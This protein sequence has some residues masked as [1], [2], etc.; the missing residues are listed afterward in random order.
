MGERLPQVEQFVPE[1]VDAYDEHVVDLPSPPAVEVTGITCHSTSSTTSTTVESSDPCADITCPEGEVCI[2]GSCAPTTH[3]LIDLDVDQA[4]HFG[5]LQ[6]DILHDCAEGTFDGEDDQV[7]C[8]GNPD[9]NAYSAFHDTDCEVASGAPRVSL[10]AITLNSFMGPVRVATC[11]YSDSTG[12]PPTADRFRIVVVDAS[13]PDLVPI[14]DVT[15]SVGDIRPS[16]TLN[17]RADTL[18]ERRSTRRPTAIVRRDRFR[19]SRHRLSR[20]PSS[21]ASIPSRNPSPQR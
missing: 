11:E 6:F 1:V 20:F 3:Y 15:V 17:G 19:R 5:A 9:L 2:D 12:S 8:V 21:H 4:E 14:P 13:D 18:I 7:H 10:S 16:P